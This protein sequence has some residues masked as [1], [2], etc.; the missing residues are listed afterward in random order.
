MKS[1]ALFFLLVSCAHAQYWPFFFP[2][3]PYPPAPWY[4]P[5]YNPRPAYSAPYFP[6][7]PSNSEYAV[8]LG[9]APVG[10]YNRRRNTG[11]FGTTSEGTRVED[12][13]HTY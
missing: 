9:G 7:Q 1:V 3:V 12:C 5:F 11:P 2:F 4:S 6:S 8:S 13:F 10:L